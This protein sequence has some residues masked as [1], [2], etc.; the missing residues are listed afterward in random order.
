MF[1]YKRYEIC[2]LL[3]CLTFMAKTRRRAPALAVT[4]SSSISSLPSS[5]PAPTPTPSTSG[6]RSHGSIVRSTGEDESTDI[7]LI[8]PTRKRSKGMSM[9]EKAQQFREMFPEHASDEQ[10][11]GTLLCCV[12]RR[13]CFIDHS[14]AKQMKGWSSKFYSHYTLPPIINKSDPVIIKYEFHCKR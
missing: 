11:L 6:K 1:L 8:T 7:E 13:P 12:L 5:S 3:D 10:I 2:I 4:R 14:P 9:H